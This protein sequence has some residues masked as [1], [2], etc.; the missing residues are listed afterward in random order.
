MPGDA[1][2]AQQELG[3]FPDAHRLTTWNRIVPW[4]RLVTFARPSPVRM[5]A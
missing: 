3:G 4:I 2:L 5:P 1:L